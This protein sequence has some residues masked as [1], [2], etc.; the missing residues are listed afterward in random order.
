[1][2]TPNSRYSKTPMYQV[3][4]ANGRTVS[5]V[6][7]PVR[8]RPALV[9]FHQL[10][11][12]QRLDLLASY[13]LKDPTAFWRLCDANGAVSPHALASHPLIGIPRQER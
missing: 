8:H 9:G 12:G 2:F 13:Y 3:A 6:A 1:M 4:L 7:F 5:V 10:K 11:E